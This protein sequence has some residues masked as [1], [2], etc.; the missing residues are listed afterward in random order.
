MKGILKAYFRLI[1]SLIKSQ[2]NFGKLA[3]NYKIGLRIFLFF[4]SG[5]KIFGVL[6][7]L[8]IAGLKGREKEIGL[9]QTEHM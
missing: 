7:M 5:T 4:T 1:S 3:M 6:P 8:L 2:S 9:Y